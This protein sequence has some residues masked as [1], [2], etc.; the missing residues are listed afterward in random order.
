MCA[1][2]LSALTVG[3]AFGGKE[4]SHAEPP[5]PRRQVWL[6][7]GRR[8]GGG[9]LSARASHPSWAFLATGCPMV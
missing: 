2:G 9:P 4:G 5:A 7:G 6:G 1:L 8:P 3:R